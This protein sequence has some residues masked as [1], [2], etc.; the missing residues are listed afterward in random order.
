MNTNF[1]EVCSL[2]RPYIICDR[3]KKMF[4]RAF[5]EDVSFKGYDMK[6]RFLYSLFGING[7]FGMVMQHFYCCLMNGLIMGYKDVLKSALLCM[8]W[9][10]IL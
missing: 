7:V 10:L 6:L 3:K 4:W 5:L 8:K 9:S 1:L 2:I